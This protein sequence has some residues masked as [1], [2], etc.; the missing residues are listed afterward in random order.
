M[1]N[2][3]QRHLVLQCMVNQRS[4]I[5]LEIW[6]MRIHLWEIM[7]KTCCSTPDQVLISSG[8]L[9]LPDLVKCQQSIKR[10]ISNRMTSNQLSIE[11]KLVKAGK[12]MVIPY[13]IKL[14]CKS[15]TTLY[16][17]GLVRAMIGFSLY[18]QRLRKSS[19]R[20]K[21]FWTRRTRKKFRQWWIKQNKILNTISFS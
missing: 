20:L 6:G 17:E 8:K 1:I 18:L 7:I 10:Q 15:Q 19:V 2:Q 14:S 13:L 12:L 21:S 4:A 9:I 11:L 5:I 16:L 3:S